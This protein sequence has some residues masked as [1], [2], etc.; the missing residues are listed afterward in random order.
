MQLLEPK[1]PIKYNI[2]DERFIHIKDMENELDFL[3]NMFFMK[4]LQRKVDT[5][6]VIFVDEYEF[7]KITNNMSCKD[8]T[9]I[10][11]ENNPDCIN[12]L[13]KKI[14]SP[15]TEY[16]GLYIHFEINR[17]QDLIFICPQRIKNICDDKNRNLDFSSLLKMVFVHELGHALLTE[18]PLS[19]TENSVYSIESCQLIEES[20][21]NAFA[22]LHFTEPE[23]KALTDFCR[24]QSAG[25]RNFETWGNE[26]IDVIQNMKIF[27]EFKSRYSVDI[28]ISNFIKSNIPTSIIEK[29]LD[30]WPTPAKIIELMTIQ[31]LTTNKTDDK[32]HKEYRTISNINKLNSGN[33]ITINEFN[34]SQ[35]IKVFNTLSKLKFKE[36]EHFGIYSSN[37]FSSL[38]CLQV[39]KL[40]RYEFIDNNQLSKFKQLFNIS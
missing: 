33:E 31:N 30:V 37:V 16:L 5:I 9:S 20:L 38:I 2:D 4:N 39:N 13:I 32:Q 28:L 25:Y 11:N 19:I 6:T 3:S 29:S 12:D 15:P 8:K 40:Q 1:M 24:Q 7:C 14:K 26:Y 21:C 10:E 18:D 17:G 35:R 27:R 36:I 23:H 22:M 34:P